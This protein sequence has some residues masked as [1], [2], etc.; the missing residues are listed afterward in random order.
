MT[1]RELVKIQPGYQFRGR[2]TPAHDGDG[3]LVQL[4]DVDEP[5]DFIPRDL[6]RIHTGQIGEQYHLSEDDILLPS[7]GRHS[8]AV[9][10]K[11]KDKTIAAGQFYIIRTENDQLLPGYLCWFLNTRKAQKHLQRYLRGTRMPILSKD[12][13][14]DLEIPLPPLEQQKTISELYR[15]SREEESLSNRLQELRTEWLESSVLEHVGQV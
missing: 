13:L 11:P 1:L 6:T 9:V 8:Y 10:V 14:K 4:K 5:G 2:V 3:F 7:R 15:L 12:G